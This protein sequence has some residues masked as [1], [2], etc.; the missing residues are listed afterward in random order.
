[1]VVTDENLNLL[2]DGLE[3]VIHQDEEIL[4]NMDP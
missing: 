2:D 3:I 1:V 4:K